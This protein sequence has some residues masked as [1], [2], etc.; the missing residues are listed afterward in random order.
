[1]QHQI[2]VEHGH[3]SLKQIADIITRAKVDWA[4]CPVTSS[5]YVHIYAWHIHTQICNH[6]V[7]HNTEKAVLKK[8]DKSCVRPS[9]FINNSLIVEQAEQTGNVKGITS[10]DDVIKWKYFPHYCPF[11]RGIHRSPVNSP[12][13]GQW[14]RALM[15]SLICTWINGW[16][17]NGEAGDSRRH[18]AHYDVTVMLQGMLVKHTNG[19]IEKKRKEEITIT[20]DNIICNFGKNGTSCWEINDQFLAS[21]ILST[22]KLLQGL[23]RQ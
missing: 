5:I 6:N 21:F 8:S 22:A 23:L 4:H 14:C 3:I 19:Y 20:I 12:H 17:N 16:V 13:K 7:F 1:M 2:P 15:F 11:V 18:R 10:H 9:V